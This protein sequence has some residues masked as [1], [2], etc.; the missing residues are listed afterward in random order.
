[1]IGRSL[2]RPS[3]I[4][5]GKIAPLLFDSLKPKHIETILIKYYIN[6]HE[7]LQLA[8]AIYSITYGIPRLIYWAIS[9]IDELTQL[10]RQQFQ[11]LKDVN[12]KYFLKECIKKDPTS[13]NMERKMRSA[14][15]ELY[16]ISLFHIQINAEQKVNPEQWGIEGLTEEMPFI[17]VAWYLGAF[18]HKS[19]PSIVNMDYQPS[20]ML[21]SSD[22]QQKSEK[23]TD[24]L[25]YRGISEEETM[26]VT[27]EEDNE[28]GDENQSNE[29]DIVQQPELLC[30]IVIPPILI[31]VFFRNPQS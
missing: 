23:F 12:F 24:H 11:P 21:P 25:R 13:V 22:N 19:P 2:Y 15:I 30:Y 18:L 4:S 10:H 29:M 7:R 20:L 14:Y 8:K 17:S 26:S 16:K 31:E 9:Y 28:S 27:D 6:R 1:V 5:P 3:L